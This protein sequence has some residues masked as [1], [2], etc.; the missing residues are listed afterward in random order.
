MSV[1]ADGHIHSCL[2]CVNS[3][4]APLKTISLPR[5]ELEAVLLFSQLYQTVKTS[6]GDRVSKVMLWSE[7]IIVLG[8]LKTKLS[9]L[10]T[11]VANRVAKIQELTMD[12]IWQHVPS[13]DNPADLISRE[14]TIDILKQSSLW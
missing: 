11:F 10:K 1:D 5:L 12:A 9:T 4:I 2:L 7:S 13:K 14:V 6:L 8:G 3:K